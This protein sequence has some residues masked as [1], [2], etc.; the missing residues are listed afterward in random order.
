MVAPP[1][2]QR[3][4]KCELGCRDGKLHRVAPPR[5]ERGLKSAFK[6]VWEQ[7]GLVA[8]PRGERGLKLYFCTDYLYEAGLCRSPSWGAWIEMC[9]ES[10]KVISSGVAPPRGERGLKSAERRGHAG[11]HGGRSPSWGAWIEIQGAV[12]KWETARGRSPS[13]GAWIEI[14]MRCSDSLH[15]HVAPPR[16]ERGLKYAK[17]LKKKP[18]YE[19][20]PL[21]GSVD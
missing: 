10:I 18:A 12:A 17:L 19:S 8:P 3:G 16:G 13:W 2:G 15:A 21:V 4:L 11:H 1:R 20:L 9:S 7:Y 6:R 5:G 14:P